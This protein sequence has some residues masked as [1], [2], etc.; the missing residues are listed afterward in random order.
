L[1]N[2]RLLSLY[3]N[4]V[5]VDVVFPIVQSDAVTEAEDFLVGTV[6]VACI[7]AVLVREVA[8]PYRANISNFYHR[9]RRDGVNN[10][11]K[12]LR[13][14][15]L[16]ITVRSIVRVARRNLNRAPRF[17]HWNAPLRHREISF[18]ALERG[19]VGPAQFG[20]AIVNVVGVVDLNVPRIPGGT[21][22][23]LE[24][25]RSRKCCAKVG[26]EVRV[27]G[28]GVSRPHVVTEAIGIAH[29][30]VVHHVFGPART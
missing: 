24:F 17:L 9:W 8:H 14:R 19:W 6:L 3:E 20:C 18:E 15:R 16:A 10:V 2:N 21:L 13:L 22:D 12:I 26:T 7:T 27:D 4:S 23:P 25:A 1:I 5:L 30:E 11:A 29:S 28:I